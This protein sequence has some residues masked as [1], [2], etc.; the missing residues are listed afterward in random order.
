MFDFHRQISWNSDRL[1]KELTDAKK[2]IL[3]FKTTWLKHTNSK[4]PDQNIQD[5]KTAWSNMQ[6]QKLIDQNTQIQKPLDQ[7]KNPTQNHLT[8]LK[9]WGLIKTFKFKITCPKH[10]NLESL[11]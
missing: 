6:V 7:K 11:D 9:T 4:P 2:K 1:L 8:K 3:Q 5:C 10:S